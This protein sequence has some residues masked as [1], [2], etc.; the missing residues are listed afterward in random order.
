MSQCAKKIGT[1]KARVGGHKAT[2][3]E[4]TLAVLAL[5]LVACLGL[6]VAFP[7]S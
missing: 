5:L 7:L 4:E 2:S 1:S 6:F 3:A